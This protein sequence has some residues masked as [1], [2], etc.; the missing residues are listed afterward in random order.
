MI[1][2]ITSRAAIALALAAST[3]AAYAQT[4]ITREITNQPVETIIER[5][6]AGTVITRRPLAAPTTRS[7]VGFPAETVV[8]EPVEEV[9]LPRETVGVSATTVTPAAET[10]TT[11]RVTSE[12]A[13]VAPRPRQVRSGTAT[14][15]ARTVTRPARTTTV[16]RTV[17]VAPVRRP[18]PDALALTA[19]QRTRIYRAVLQ[20]RSVPRTVITEPY[21]EPDYAVPVVR[22][23]VVAERIVQPAAPVVSER[24]VT[25]PPPRET[26]GLAPRMVERVVTTPAATEL[27]IGSRVPRTVPLYAL[28]ASIGAPALQP[29]RYAIVDDRV[30]LVDPTTELIV[31]ELSE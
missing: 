9:V 16:R 13:R 1:G 12:R 28:P 10:V 14:T 7:T 6:P 21:S 20:Q 24:F 19:T 2:A 22:E 25:V 18:A 29:Y 11:R 8:S 5:G 31:S 30:F 23:D 4:V 27:T 15:Q 17:A 26:Y 3:G